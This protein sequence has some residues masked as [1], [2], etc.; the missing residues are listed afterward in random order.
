MKGKYDRE[1]IEIAITEYNRERLTLLE[2]LDLMVKGF[3]AP[4]I[5]EGS[6]RLFA[7]HLNELFG[8]EEVFTAFSIS[9][10]ICIVLGDLKSQLEALRDDTVTSGGA[11]TGSQLKALGISEPV[12]AVCVNFLARVRLSLCGLLLSIS[13]YIKLQATEVLHILRIVQNTNGVDPAWSPLSITVISG[14]QNLERD[15]EFTTDQVKTLK[16]INTVLFDETPK[17]TY[18][19]LRGAVIVQFGIFLKYARVK[20]PSLEEKLG[21]HTSIEE[22]ITQNVGE[23]SPFEFIKENLISFATLES[24]VQAVDGEVEMEIREL[25]FG[26]LQRM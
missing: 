3:S 14:I 4:A 24:P 22:R 23:L 21:F 8:R 19:G 26:V 1:P 10:K 2:C 15:I 7:H 12:I 18:K 13:L 16:D 20:N 9:I 5:P 11:Q 17:W 25:T 6:R